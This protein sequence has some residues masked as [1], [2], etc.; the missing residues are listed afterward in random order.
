MCWDQRT[1]QNLQL[2]TLGNPLFCTRSSNIS[3]DVNPVVVTSDVTDGIES[4]LSQ[5]I[6]QSAFT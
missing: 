3:R 2:E 5:M 6:Y 1:R 4:L